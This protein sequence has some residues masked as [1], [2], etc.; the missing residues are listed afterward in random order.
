MSCWCGWAATA[1]GRNALTGLSDD[2]RVVS[3]IPYPDTSAASLLASVIAVR[4]GWI[5]SRAASRR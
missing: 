4:N 2:G 3:A 1:C 5:L